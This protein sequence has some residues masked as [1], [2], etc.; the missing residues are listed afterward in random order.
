MDTGASDH[1][2]GD[3]VER[4]EAQ[5]TEDT[6][7]PIATVSGV[8]VPEAVGT[9]ETPIGVCQYVR[10]IPQS[11]NLLSLGTLVEDQGFGFS[12]TSSE[13]PYLFYPDGTKEELPV[14]NRVPYLGAVN[15]ALALP[16]LQ[17]V[18]MQ[19]LEGNI[20]ELLQEFTRS[21]E[22]EEAS[23]RG[24]RRALHSQGASVL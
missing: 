1:I 3:P 10:H 6:L 18:L 2:S 15:L 13:G 12:W 17:E 16:A 19:E 4:V 5:E 14:H 20:D 8:V 24:L 9:L 22:L 7:Q 23:F 11:P 21:V